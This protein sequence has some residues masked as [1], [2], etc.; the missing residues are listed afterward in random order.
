MQD[1]QMT[2]VPVGKS[3]DDKGQMRHHA[4]RLEASI[5]L[6]HFVILSLTLLLPSFFLATCLSIYSSIYN[7]IVVAI[8]PFNYLLSRYDMYV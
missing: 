8:H 1:P 5:Y 4:A 6:L 2:T 7:S 3:Q